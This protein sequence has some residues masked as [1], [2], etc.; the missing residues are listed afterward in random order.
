VL[1][2]LHS[3]RSTIENYL[4]NDDRAG[5]KGYVDGLVVLAH[6]IGAS[7]MKQRLKH[8]R[9][10]ISGDTTLAEFNPYF[11]SLDTMMSEAEYYLKTTE[12]FGF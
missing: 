2:T 8:I 5:L 3:S 1:E 10:D 11:L 6:T 12:M 4:Q 7:Q 9:Q